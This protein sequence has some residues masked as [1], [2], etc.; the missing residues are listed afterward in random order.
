[1]IPSTVV[2]VSVIEE[3]SCHL[4][5]TNYEYPERTFSQT[6]PQATTAVPSI[7][8]I[9]DCILMKGVTDAVLSAVEFII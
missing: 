4:W 7:P 9:I 6:S 5:T 2:K 3:A 8:S 1:M